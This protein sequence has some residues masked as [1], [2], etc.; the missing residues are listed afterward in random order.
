MQHSVVFFQFTQNDRS[1]FSYCAGHY[2]CT[3]F[4]SLRSIFGVSTNQNSAARGFERVTEE[5]VQ[6][7]CKGEAALDLRIPWCAP[8]E[9]ITDTHRTSCQSAT[10]TTAAPKSPWKSAAHGDSVIRQINPKMLPNRIDYRFRAGK[11]L[12]KNISRSGLMIVQSWLVRKMRRQHM[13]S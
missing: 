3:Q 9:E 6:F 7:F 4:F 1:C 12:M 8:P 5:I 2:F 13:I 11:A 10:N